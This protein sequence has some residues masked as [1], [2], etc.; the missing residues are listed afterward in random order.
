[1]TIAEILLT[2]LAGFGLLQVGIKMISRN[3]GAMTGNRLRVGINRA[4]RKPSLAAVFGTVAGFA[5]QSTRT[6][7]FVAASFVQ[8]GMLDV[9]RALPIVVWANLGSTF[10]IFAA[11]FPFHL[12]VLFLLAL[13]AIPVALERPKA[14]LKA[15]SAVFGL[16]L[17]LFGLHMMSTSTGLLA[18]SEMAGGPLALLNRSLVL[19]FVVGLLLTCVTQS[20]LAATL[21]IL[22]A[23][24]GRIFGLEQALLLA[25][26]AQA[27]HSLLTFVTGM[28][29]RGQSRQVVLG[30]VLYNLPAVAIFLIPFM[31]DRSLAGG[32]GLHWL[33]AELGLGPGT[34]TGIALLAINFVAPLI[35]TVLLSPF[36]AL[37]IRL[38]P[39]RGDETLAQPQYLR[40]EVE[41][42]AVAT[43]M[44]A[45]KEQLRLLRRLPA[46]C[47][48]LRGTAGVEGETSPHDYHEAFAL[49]SDAIERA[50]AT[51]VTH[52][53]TTEDTEWLLNQ[54]KRQELLRTL[55]EACF[56]L[57]QLAGGVRADLRPLRDNIVEALDTL[58][59][60]SID[61]FGSGDPADI[62]VL[63]VMT[64]N[65]GAAM[66]RIR[67][68]YLAI[69]DD[70]TVEQRSF[71]LQMTSLYERAAWSVRRFAALIAERPLLD[72]ADRAAV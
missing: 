44:L 41:E 54:Q 40:H 48:A 4:S 46:Y 50:Q 56:E 62:E 64:G 61:A 27:G 34:F 18:D 28:Q 47:E 60:F 42:N 52:E 70:L 67:R 5:T 2:F 25:L 10:V 72:T 51:L 66:E 9:R 19:A 38:A 58:L 69:S 63:D 14:I 1:M 57:W 20:Q 11:I 45:E 30:Q 49:V 13:S 39:P 6:I 43:L 16:A 65:H 68:R 35:V 17:M 7:C 32:Q 55:D 21:I 3:L 26:G 53:M 59:L 24:Q 33:V 12:V 71:I 29:F 31:V 37:C 23:A 15:A 22:A 8:A 36:Y